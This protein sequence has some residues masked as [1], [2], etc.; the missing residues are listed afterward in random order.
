VPVYSYTCRACGPTEIIKPMDEASHPEVCLTC[1]APLRRIY[2]PQRII[3]RPS[4]YNLHPED[5]RY[6][7]FDRELELGE[8]RDPGDR[9]ESGGA[10]ATPPPVRVD[11]SAAS[12]EAERNLHQA[13]AAALAE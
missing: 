13:V 11:H 9:S 12:Y 6:S 1:A 4:G 2:N 3:I 10:D 5:P 7:F 8:V